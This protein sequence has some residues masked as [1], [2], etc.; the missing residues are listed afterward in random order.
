[1]SAGPGAFE[2]VRFIWFWPFP[3]QAVPTVRACSGVPILR[4][5]HYFGHPNGRKK[6]FVRLLFLVAQAERMVQGMTKVK[7]PRHQLDRRLLAAFVPPWKSAIDKI[8]FS[9]H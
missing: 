5:E 2:L 8:L 4:V 1:V 7:I 6:E 9:N 3:F